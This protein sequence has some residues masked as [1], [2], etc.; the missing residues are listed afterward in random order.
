MKPLFSESISFL[1]DAAKYDI[2]SSY[3]CFRGKKVSGRKGDISGRWIYPASLPD[4]K[5]VFLMKILLTNYC[6][7][8]CAYCIN[9]KSS[10]VKRYS[11]EPSKLA[12]LFININRKKIA[13][14]LF[15]TSAVCKNP[16]STMD[17]MI[18]T[19]E[20]LRK[21]YQYKGYIHLK[22]LPG[23]SFEAINKAILLADRVSVNI[24]APSSET[25]KILTPQ[26]DFYEDIILRMKWI[27]ESLL[28]YPRHTITYKRNNYPP[29]QTTQFVVGAAGENDKEILTTTNTLYLKFNL[30]RVYFSA[31]QPIDDS[32]LS[33]HPPTPLIREHRLYQS[34]F[35]I[36]KYNFQID[37]IIFDQRGNLPEKFD[38]KYNWAIHH[39]DFFPVEVNKAGK[40][41]LLRIPGIGPMTASRI[42]KERKKGVLKSLDDISK[43]GGIVKRARDFI[44]LNGKFYPKPSQLSLFS[45]I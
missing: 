10:N 42:I 3:L 6:E 14:G 45:N 18:E 13:D 8:D 40:D 31:F 22:I 30:A 25:L 19:I 37:E 28:N 15:L 36:R 27:N 32:P 38:P 24:E 17:K 39:P 5:T 4:G 9:R 12:E 2:C 7:N 41:E 21:K 16:D 26:K 23:A 35:L 43:L 20:L 11:I 44:L 33:S 29:T 1:A 34:D